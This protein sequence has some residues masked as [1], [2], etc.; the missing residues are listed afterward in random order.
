LRTEVRA[1]ELHM[2]ARLAKTKKRRNLIRRKLGATSKHKRENLGTTPSFPLEGPLPA[3]RYGFK[4]DP[5]SIEVPAKL[6]K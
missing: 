2:P 4:V 3:L 5:A 1:K 6:L